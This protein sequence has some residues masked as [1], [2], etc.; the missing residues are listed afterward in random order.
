MLTFL[1]KHPL[2]IALG[3]GL[4]VLSLYLA[5]RKHNLLLSGHLADGEVVE[6]VPHSGSKGGPTYS[7]RVAYT[8]SDGAK[9]EFETTFSTNPPMHQLGEKVRVVCY[10]GDTTPDIL[11]FADLYLFP[12]ACFCAGVFVLLMCTG[13][14]FGPYLIDSVYLP[15]LTNPDPLKT[16]NLLK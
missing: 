11:A 10:P 15:H 16:L 3:F 1:F 6:L 13:F 2:I 9:A 8:Q 7:V 5:W 4:I 14:A 12:W